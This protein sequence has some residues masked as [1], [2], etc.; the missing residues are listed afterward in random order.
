[1]KSLFLFFTLFGSLFFYYEREEGT[2]NIE[3]MPIL[4]G[5]FSFSKEWVYP[6]GISKNEYGQLVCDG[7]C[8]PEVTKMMNSKGKIKKKFLNDFYEVVDTIHQFYSL[9]SQSN[10][11]EWLNPHFAEVVKNKDSTYTVSSLSDPATHISLIIEIKANS[12]YPKAELNSISSNENYT[13]TLDEGHFKVDKSYFDKGILKAEFDFKFKS[14]NPEKEP[15]FWK[16]KI[17]TEI[18]E[19]AISNQL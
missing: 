14:D 19:H 7:F 3:W 13:Y 2:I 15:Y 16:G 4:E 6:E 11:P 9:E 5:D 1:M 18:K 10:C 17:Y 12:C 8:P